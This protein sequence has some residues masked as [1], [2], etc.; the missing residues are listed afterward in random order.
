[1]VPYA[2]VLGGA[3][4]HDPVDPELI[5]RSQTAVGFGAGV[6]IEIAQR[7]GV[8]FDWRHLFVQLEDVFDP[9]NRSAEEIESDRIGVGL[10]WRF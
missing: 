6:E 4:V 3:V 10:F 7:I 5:T 9:Q 1:M 2:G 8:H